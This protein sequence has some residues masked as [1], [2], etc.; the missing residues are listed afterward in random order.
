MFHSPKFSNTGAS[1]NVVMP[2]L[3]TTEQSTRINFFDIV[4]EREKQ[5][6]K[7]RRNKRERKKDE[8]RKKKGKTVLDSGWK[9]YQ[10]RR[11]FLTEEWK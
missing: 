1:S 5:R 9:S 6:K 2:R 7:E 8:E 11:L 3:L 10:L 4:I